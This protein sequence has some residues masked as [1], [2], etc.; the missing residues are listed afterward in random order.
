M[1][2][3]D[4]DFY[5]ECGLTTVFNIASKHPVLAVPSGLGANGAPTGVQIV[6]HTY[7]DVACFRVGAAL[8]REL[9]WWRDPS[10]GPR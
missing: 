6:A 8:E 3:V 7:D 4:L 10:W 5:F 1:A 9:G 2:G